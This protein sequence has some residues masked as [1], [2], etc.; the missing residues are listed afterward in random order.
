M[1]QK[2]INVSATQRH[3]SQAECFA[4]EPCLDR[5]GKE[6]AASR[7]EESHSHRIGCFELATKVGDANVNSR[8]MGLGHC[9]HVYTLFHGCRFNYLSSQY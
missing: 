2:A 5:A 4:H 6:K 3:G 1:V 9:L 7:D 8:G